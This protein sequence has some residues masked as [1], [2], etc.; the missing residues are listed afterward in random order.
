[1][2]HP[3]DRSEIWLLRSQV[4]GAHVTLCCD[5][6]DSQSRVSLDRVQPPWALEVS[7]N[8]LLWLHSAL[9][10][11]NWFIQVRRKDGDLAEGGRLRRDLCQVK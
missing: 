1:M 5:E 6:D 11:T 2:G 4:D 8:N 7:P 3:V 9:T 10:I